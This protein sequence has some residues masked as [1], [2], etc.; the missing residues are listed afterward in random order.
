MT[1]TPGAKLGH[2]EIVAP[3]GAGGMG[4]VYRARDT[5]LGREVAIKVLPEAFSSD[6]ERLARLQREAQMLAT[7][8]HP[9]IAGIYALEESGV[10]RF[11]AL[12]FVP[13][14][15]LA[16]LLA[17]R[18][19][20]PVSEALAIA[21][22]LAEALEAAHEKGVVHRDL[23]PANIKLT[24]EGKVKVL[25]FGL[26]KLFAPEASSAEMTHSPTLSVVATR[27]GVLL[28]TAA[29]MSP[30]QAR[31]KSLDRRTDIWAFGCVLFEL[32]TG[33]QAFAGE[34]V[35]DAVAVI[36]TREPDWQ[37]LP[38]ATPPR[39][40]EL[41][42]RCLQKDAG[43][44]LRDMGDA[45]IEIEEIRAG[46]GSGIVPSVAAADSG[47]AAP[48]AS[49]S[50]W[51]R[52]VTLGRAAGAALSLAGVLSLLVWV[53][54]R[55]GQQAPSPV[56]RV[57]I[58]TPKGENLFQI[59][60]PLVA[61]SPDSR[62]VV[63]VAGHS[64]ESQLFL[65]SLDQL[66]ATPIPGTQ[67]ARNPLFS[68]NG[69]WI[70]FFAG[71][72]LKKISV[73]GGSALPLCDAAPE[74][75]RG[76]SWGDD[77]YIYF[78]P[79]FVGGIVRVAESGGKLEAVTTPDEKT[80]ER[81]HRWPE[82]LPGGKALLYT[83]GSIKSPDYYFD[84]QIAVRSLATSQTKVLVD[85]GTNAHYLPSGHLLYSTASG[86]VAVPFDVG[87][88]ELTGPPIPLTEQILA[89]VD[90]GAMHYAVSR[91][92]VLAYAPGEAPNAERA[93]VWLDLKGKAEP[94]AAPR[95]SY[96]EP[97]LSPDGKR[98]AVTLPGPRNDDI[99]LLD[100]QRN[101]LT[102]LTFGP[103]A[104]ISPLWAPDGK[105]VVYASERDGKPGLF[106]KPA[107]GSGSEERLLTA[108]TGTSFPAPESFSP[109]GKL[110]IFSQ[111]DPVRQSDIYVLSLDDRKVQP[112]LATPFNESGGALSPDGRWIAYQSTESGPESL[113]VQAFPGP[114]GKWQIAS[115]GGN[116][117]WSRDGKQ[118]FFRGLSD[119]AGQTNSFAKV[120]VTTKPSFAASTPQTLFSVPFGGFRPSVR[121]VFSVAPDS[122]R[123]LIVEGGEANQ[124]R[125]QLNLVFGLTGELKRRAASSR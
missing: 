72:K 32:L 40:R 19:A 105:H 79:A 119:A 78:T 98:V 49:A 92:G 25:D 91:E 83:L 124:Q 43:H 9:N 97:T 114:G 76:A 7:L 34:T 66:E 33:R 101:T 94:L 75:S 15:T 84:A 4:E 71:G 2:Y 65:R 111:I 10:A 107:D 125:N 110:L 56:L 3:V 23:K 45:R 38:P 11:L 30:E 58:P 63:F 73:R 47:F 29:Y 93:L 5:R 115:T 112:F 86:L 95:R 69:E 89:S 54:V 31:G 85:G 100:I 90:T 62:T 99:W 8:N 55:G 117:H 59:N 52:P 102:R 53:G 17:A 74:D 20:L 67:G 70:G 106:R 121:S 44:R 41:L 109:D 12:E 88:L 108:S 36:L 81:T 35:S 21:G 82:L 48:V 68:P 96:Y 122:R 113:Y 24:P 26:A 28:G 104:A 60:Q 16:A 64:G 116:P 14:E 103:A 50:F 39:V 13:G 87:K 57:S 80:G 46:Q 61:I 6:R 51:A 22:Q 1:L 42:R 37:S 27:A 120:D 77:G 118:L 123:I 18:G